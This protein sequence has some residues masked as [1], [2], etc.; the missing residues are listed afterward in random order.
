VTV[1]TDPGWKEQSLFLLSQDGFS[2][3]SP[4]RMRQQTTDTINT[5]RGHIDMLSDMEAFNLSSSFLQAFFRLAWMVFP[6]SEIPGLNEAKMKLRRL[7]TWTTKQFF[8]GCRAVM[9]WCR[10]V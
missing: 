1:L 4:L 5:A 8:D 10:V 2:R 6:L 9:Y 3:I 7:H